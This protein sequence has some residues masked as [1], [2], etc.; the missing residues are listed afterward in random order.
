MPTNDDISLKLLHLRF[1]ITDRSIFSN[2]LALE[3][4]ARVAIIGLGVKSTL[5]WQ[6]DLSG[7]Q[8][9]IKSEKSTSEY[10]RCPK[11]LG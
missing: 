5:Q 1:D 2:A 10:N 7:F 3:S 4:A 6:M 8:W 11:S 9:V